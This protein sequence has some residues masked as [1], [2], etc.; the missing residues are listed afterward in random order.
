PITTL[1]I[2]VGVSSINFRVR[3]PRGET[4]NVS[5]DDG[6]GGRTPGTDSIAIGPDR[7]VFTFAPIISVNHCRAVT[8]RT[9]DTLGNDTAVLSNTTVNLAGVG[10]G[11]FNT[12][13]NCN[14]AMNISSLTFNTGQATKNIY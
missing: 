6:A 10:N 7:L 9:R 2:G 13:V 12:D 5:I 11:T 4:A 3:D 14:P 1:N 8:V